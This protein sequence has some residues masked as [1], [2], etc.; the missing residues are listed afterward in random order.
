VEITRRE[1]LSLLFGVPLACRRRTPPIAGA[2]VD[3]DLA[4]GH[5]LRDGFAFDAGGSIE[6][7]PF[8]VVGAGVAGLSAARRLAKAGARFRV[9]ELSSDPGGTARAGRSP[10]TRYPWGA[11]Y[12]PVPSASNTDLLELFAELGIAMD[13]VDRV[14][15]PKERVFYRGEWHHGLYPPCS[16]RD[17]EEH[18]RFEGLIDRFAATVGADGRR[19]FSIPIAHGSDDPAILALDGM[20]MSAWLDAQ[21][22]GSSLL[23]WSVDYACRDDFGLAADHTS[24]WYGLH[25]F[26]SRIAEPGEDA[27]EL[28]AW[29]EGN[30]RVVDRMVDRI[31]R[32]RIA[33]DTMAVRIEP[34]AGRAR[35]TLFDRRRGTGSI[36]LADRIIFALPSFLR[37]RV[38]AGFG[39]A[40]YRPA[41]APWLVANVHLSGRPAYRGFEP[42]WDNVIAFSRSLGYVVATHQTGPDHGPT[43]LTYYLPFSGE[44][45]RRGRAEL[46]ALT[47]REAVE[48][49]AAELSA[50]HPGIERLIDR[51]D[52]MRWG[53]GMVQPRR[54]LR[55]SAERIAAAR[56]VGPISFAHTDLSGVALFEEA[57]FHGDRAA[58]EAL[59]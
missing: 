29:P 42:A 22:F 33:T 43:V 48:A 36:V 57:F 2:F 23:R 53:H 37:S 11:H 20:T 12:I 28:L 14:A 34:A 25:Y 32:E 26:A 44:D 3:D 19:A 56:P 27:A 16:G 18:D 38:I 21:G 51:V 7:I 54:G 55:T 1:L 47:H 17:L 10:V 45:D 8:L 15:A 31:G 40:P 39:E 59:L 24:A 9:V 50:V 5:R 49:I 30:A 58:R 52:L 46:L 13:E 35:V 6:E 41:Y 4:D